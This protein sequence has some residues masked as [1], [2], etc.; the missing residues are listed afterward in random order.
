[1]NGSL[2]MC[3]KI[4]YLSPHPLSQVPCRPYSFPPQFLREYGISYFWREA[5]KFLAVLTIY[6]QEPQI[7]TNNS[8]SLSSYFQI[9]LNLIMTWGQVKKVHLWTELVCACRFASYISFCA[10]FENCAQVCVD[11]LSL[12][13]RSSAILPSFPEWFKSKEI[14]S[15]PQKIDFYNLFW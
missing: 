13:R 7:F 8:L 1:M 2:E 12:R 3:A 6:K 11:F 5:S 9:S 14:W 4:C 10:R 15:Y